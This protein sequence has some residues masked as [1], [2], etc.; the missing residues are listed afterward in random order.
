MHP[1][2]APAAPLVLVANGGYL[3]WIRD[4]QIPVHKGAVLRPHPVMLVDTHRVVC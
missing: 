4:L 1:G 2:I 3:D